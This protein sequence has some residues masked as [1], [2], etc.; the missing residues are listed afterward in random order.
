MSAEIVKFEISDLFDEFDHVLDLKN[1]SNIVGQARIAVMVGPNGVGKTTIF[2]M[3]AGMLNLDFNTFRTVPFSRAALT[4]STGDVLIV[5]RSLDEQCLNVAFNDK[6]AKLSIASSGPL[7]K[8]HVEDVE[9]LKRAANSVLKIV[10]FEKADIH[11]SIAL[12]AKETEQSTDQSL[13]ESQLEAHYRRSIG[14][15]D[16][17]RSEPSNLSMKV[18]KFVQEAQFDYRKY[19]SSEGPEL[20]PRILKRLHS[21]NSFTA[22]TSE[23]LGRLQ[24]IRVR[25]SE[26]ARFGLSMNI[27]DIE[28]LSSL[29]STNDETTKG[30][31]AAAA[32][33]AYVETLESKHEERELIA[34]RLSKFEEVTNRF[35]VGKKVLIDYEEGLKILTKSGRK[36]SELH[37]SS[38]EYHLLYMFVMA[39]VST[40]SGTTIAIDEPELSLH[41]SWQRQLI[42]ALSDCS[43]GASPLFLFATHSASIAAE[44]QDTWIELKARN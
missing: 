41:I 1:H 33:E 34:S 22:T 38:G 2:N 31:A 18:R 37:L 19:F 28:Q 32:L 15:L 42:N 20:F 43:A 27:G 9:E 5:E 14:K 3:I 21:R 8:Q 16:R 12:R 6:K 7:S 17:N 40:R 23:L 11:R 39:L 13:Y 4:L 25:E 26:M 30:L 24:R 36:I 35:F 29:L 44:F 10:S